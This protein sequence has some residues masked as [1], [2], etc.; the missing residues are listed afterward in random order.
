MVT[1]DRLGYFSVNYSGRAQFQLVLN[2]PGAPI[3]AGEG[4]IGFFYADVTS[5]SDGHN[6]TSGFGDGLTAINTGE[7]SHFSGNSAGASTA[8]NN[9]FVWF[10]LDGGA[11]VVIPPD[12]SVPV[13]A[14]GALLMAG[15]GAIGLLRRRQD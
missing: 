13:P 6:V 1:W 2:N 15:L 9:T 8:L 14:T 3:P 11:P 4:V 10:G 12:G 7:I 5:G